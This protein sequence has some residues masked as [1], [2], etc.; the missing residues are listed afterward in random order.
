[1]L[2]E[3]CRNLTSRINYRGQHSYRD[4]ETALRRTARIGKWIEEYPAAI[5]TSE[6]LFKM[7]DAEEEQSGAESKHG[8]IWM[9]DLSLAAKVRPRVDFKRQL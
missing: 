9:A 7:Y 3:A 6:T 5:G 4:R 1:M 8:E 2:L